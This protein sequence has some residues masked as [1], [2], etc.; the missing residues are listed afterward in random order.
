MRERYLEQDVVIGF[1]DDAKTLAP[2]PILELSHLVVTA[3]SISFGSDTDVADCINVVNYDYEGIRYTVT[4]SRW[5]SRASED[6]PWTYVADSWRSEE[7]CVAKPTADGSYRMLVQVEINDGIQYFLSNSIELTEPEPPAPTAEQ[8]F[9]D[10][11]SQSIVQGRCIN[12]HTSGGTA[13]SARL[14]FVTS[15]VDDHEASNLQE[16]RDFF[17]VQTNARTYILNKVSAQVNHGGGAQLPSGTQRYQHMD[18]FLQAI[19]RERA[20]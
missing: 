14:I 18:E 20:E 10:N 15:S 3:D 1:E 8:L 17:D 7:I 11:I 19:E 2:S 9:R 13:S 12:C 5:Q 6:M 16:F 4:N